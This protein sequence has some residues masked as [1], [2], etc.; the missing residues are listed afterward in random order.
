MSTDL[1]N[2]GKQFLL[3]A[4][5]YPNARSC[6]GVE[7]SPSISTDTDSFNADGRESQFGGLGR[8]STNYNNLV[9]NQ[10]FCS[11]K[12]IKNY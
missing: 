12:S 11:Q 2:T 7:A 5:S 8:R 9:E 6:T 3:H 4:L 10:L 1:E